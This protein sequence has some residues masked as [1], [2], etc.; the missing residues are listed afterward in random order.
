MHM[1]ACVGFLPHHSWKVICKNVSRPRM[2]FSAS[3]HC[4]WQ[5]LKDQQVWKSLIL[6]WRPRVF[7][8]TLVI[9]TWTTKWHE[10]WSK[11]G[12]LLSLS[13]G[14]PMIFVGRVSNWTIILWETGLWFLFLLTSETIKMKVKIF[15]VWQKHLLCLLLSLKLF[16]FLLVWKFLSI[17]LVLCSFHPFFKN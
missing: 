16:F 17:L 6:C 4:L 15:R 3:L 13:F 11:Y 5:Y 8:T 2:K 14:A 10:G 12:S 1:H 9:L 7:W